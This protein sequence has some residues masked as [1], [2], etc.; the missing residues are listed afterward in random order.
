MIPPPTRGHEDMSQVT[1]QISISLDG[2]VAGPDHSVEGPIGKGARHHV[3]LRHRGHRGGAGSGAGRGRRR[4]VSIA[5]GAT[6]VQQY[7]W[8]GLLDE[9]YLH[10]APVV[11]GA[12]ERLLEN[13]GD[14]TLD[15]SR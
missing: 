12:G 15:L 4:D 1:C 7:L 14:P 3:H 10:L 2:F 6:A 11:L 9:L 5:G 8:A 13:V